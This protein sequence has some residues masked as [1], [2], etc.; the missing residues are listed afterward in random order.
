MNKIINNLANKSDEIISSIPFQVYIIAGFF[1]LLF[2]GQATYQYA[3]Q[4]EPINFNIDSSFLTDPSYVKNNVY[5]G[6]VLL[7]LSPNAPSRQ[8]TEKDID[9]QLN[10]KVGDAIFRLYESRS[11]E[12]FDYGKTFVIRLS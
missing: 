8:P 7:G 2:I 3:T 9:T 5:G 10:I 6:N 11:L 4:E 1:A 12:T